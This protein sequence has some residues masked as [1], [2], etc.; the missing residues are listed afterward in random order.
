M[1][2][3]CKDQEKEGDTQVLILSSQ[4]WCCAIY[5]GDGEHVGTSFSKA[6]GGVGINSSVPASFNLRC[7][8]DVL[9]WMP[10]NWIQS[11]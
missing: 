1:E 6:W 11:L 5:G 2:L 10:T 8:I 3:K 4:G 7:L 9:V